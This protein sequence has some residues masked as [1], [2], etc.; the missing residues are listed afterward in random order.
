MGTCSSSEKFT[1]TIRVVAPARQ[2][3]EQNTPEETAVFQRINPA[4]NNL[5]EVDHKSIFSQEGYCGI[6]SIR[7]RSGSYIVGLQVCYNVNLEPKIADLMGSGPYQNDQLISFAEDEYIDMMTLYYDDVAI[8][9]IEILTT[10]EKR[11]FIGN[12]HN[13][14][15]IKETDLR[16]KERIVVGFRG[17]VGELLSDLGIYHAEVDLADVLPTRVLD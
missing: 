16:G 10:S 3:N 17:L 11:H 12:Q 6:E 9:G 14:C 7:V 15:Y 1:N 4:L 8:A 2:N 5:K 13:R